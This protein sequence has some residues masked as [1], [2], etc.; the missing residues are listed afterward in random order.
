MVDKHISVGGIALE[1]VAS[2]SDLTIPDSFVKRENKIGT[3]NGEA[4]LYVGADSATTWDFFGGPSFEISCFLLKNDLASLLDSLRSEY[5]NPTQEYVR[6]SKLLSF[7]ARREHL[8]AYVPDVLWFEAYEQG[9][10]KGTRVYMKSDSSY[11]GLIREL[12]FPNITALDIHKYK[13]NLGHF[14][15]Y[16]DP[17]LS[18]CS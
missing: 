6:K 11:F 1:H 9:Q 5:T 2:V 13:N 4:K 8:I 18:V 12:C 7:L 10:I 14:F 15:Y 3:G 17:H 16:F